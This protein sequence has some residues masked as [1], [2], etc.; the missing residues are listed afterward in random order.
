MQNTVR[1][2]KQIV[3]FLI[4]PYWNINQMVINLQAV[5]YTVSNLSILEYKFLY[6][7]LVVY[8]FYSF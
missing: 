8:T 2:V 1:T 4:Y 6:T 5:G 7:P 3:W